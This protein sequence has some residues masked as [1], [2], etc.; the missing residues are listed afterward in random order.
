MH[1]MHLHCF[2]NSTPEAHLEN[3]QMILFWVF[4]FTSTFFLLK[5]HSGVL[6]F[7]HIFNTSQVF[8]MYVLTLFCR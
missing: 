5:L 3:N 7:T 2:E 6:A 1:E 4:K 8:K